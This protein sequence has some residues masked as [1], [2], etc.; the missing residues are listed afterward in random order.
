M[1]GITKSNVSS[2]STT[3]AWRKV[4]ISDGAPARGLSARRSRSFQPS[5]RRSRRLRQ[6]IEVQY[7]GGPESSWCLWIGDSCRRVPGWMAVED[8]MALLLGEVR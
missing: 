6:R 8:A 2:P 4:K 7:R 5:Q 1:Q 3:W